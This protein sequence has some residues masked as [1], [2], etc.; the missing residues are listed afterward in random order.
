MSA[1][2]WPTGSELLDNLKN[3]LIVLCDSLYCK[4]SGRLPEYGVF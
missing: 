1:L 4:H 3:N 2:T